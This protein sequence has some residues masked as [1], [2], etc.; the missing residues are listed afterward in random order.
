MH[1]TIEEEIDLQGEEDKLCIECRQRN[2]DVMLQPCGHLQYC[3]LCLEDIHKHWRN[4]RKNRC[5]I[6]NDKITFYLKINTIHKSL[7]IPNSNIEALIKNK[8]ASTIYREQEIQINM[9]PEY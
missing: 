2:I 5:Q 7:S 9:A 4:T 1:P 6:C 3:Q 8:Q